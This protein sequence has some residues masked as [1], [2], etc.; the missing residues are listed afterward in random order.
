MRS[1]GGR[2]AEEGLVQTRPNRAGFGLRRIRKRAQAGRRVAFATAALIAVTAAW[3]LGARVRDPPEARANPP[4][5]ASAVASQA[6]VRPAAVAPPPSRDWSGCAVAKKPPIVVAERVEPLWLPA[7]P[8][9]LPDKGYAAFLEALTGVPQ[10]AKSYYRSS[11]KLRRCHYKGSDAKVQGITCEI[12]HPIVF[13]NRPGPAGQSANFGR[14]VLLALRN[15]LTA[16]PAWQQHKAEM[17]HKQVGQLEKAAWVEFRDKFVGTTEATTLIPQ[18]KN[19]IMEWRNMT[20]YH[21]EAYL[22]WEDWADDRAGPVLANKLAR[23]LTQG[24]LPVLYDGEDDVGCLWHTHLRAAIAAE[25]KKRT[26]E[27]WYAPEYTPEQ[28]GMIA[29]EL[30]AFAAEIEGQQADGEGGR[31]GDRELIGILRRYAASAREALGA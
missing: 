6:A 25:E 26:E 13:A 14:G 16:F 3:Y 19:F 1:R 23:A 5:A 22:P 4:D 29:G 10:A 7:Y 17:Y 11:P 20:P 2:G 15:P 31:P 8:T 27:G 12:V 24:G 28:R 9:A 21:V 18:W 30:D